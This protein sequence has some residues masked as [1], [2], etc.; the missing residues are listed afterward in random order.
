MT[1]VF[2]MSEETHRVWAVA[3][4]HVDV[5]MRMDMENI[6]FYGDSPLAA[7]ANRLRK[8]GVQTQVFALF[9]SVNSPGP[10]QMQGVLRGIDLFYHH[11]VVN[12][13]VEA[14]TDLQTLQHARHT[15]SIAG[16]LSLEGGGC[17]CGQTSMVRILHQLGVRGMGLTW[18][19][20][21]ELADG[22]ME[23][24]GAGLTQNGRFVVQELEN[25]SMW[26]DIAHLSDQGIYDVF[27]LAK[28][29]IMCSHANVRSVFHH[30]RNLKEDMIRELIRREGWMGLTFEA[31]FVAEG[32]VIAEQLF[33]HLDAVL[34][35]GGENHIGFGSDFDGAFNHV[36][37]LSNAADYA[38]FAELIITRYGEELGKKILFGNFESYLQRQFS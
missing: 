22:C 4:A 34:D 15:N 33:K 19:I 9:V 21:N 35:L 5:L 14:V 38:R 37:G 8:G 1:G 30:P 13:L 25:L 3:D 2:E 26:I 23:S 7:S 16:I 10:T 28:G 29:K 17:L 11:I 18:N 36:I 24:R 12:D 6:S 32:K 27:N 20:A 31:S